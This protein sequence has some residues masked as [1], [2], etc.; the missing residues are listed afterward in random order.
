MG[1]RLRT[2]LVTGGSGHIGRNVVARLR[3]DGLQVL[4]MDVRAD[5]SLAAALGVHVFMADVRDE[6]SV[7]AALE[8]VDGVIHLAG[9]SGSSIDMV[10][11]NLIGSMQVI[12]QAWEH[13]KPLV[14]GTRLNNAVLQEPAAILSHAVERFAKLSRNELEGVVNIVRIPDPYGPVPRGTQSKGL[15]AKLVQNAL[16]GETLEVDAHRIVDPVHVRD[17]ADVLV[18]AL[19]Y[20]IEVGN[21]PMP[22]ELTAGEATEAVNV[23]A[24]VAG[25]VADLTGAMAK[26]TVEES[27]LYLQQK[28]AD[29]AALDILYPEGKKFIEFGVGLEET[30][31]SARWDIKK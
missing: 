29:A 16:Q 20:G 5:P 8:H 2:V 6:R 9:V 24:E 3:A 23:A 26:I 27:Q 21:L 30:L 28:A 11:H 22:I 18:D 4:V 15:V 14:L 7:A 10:D 1:R 12:D 17:I 19:W 25:K 13:D 31:E